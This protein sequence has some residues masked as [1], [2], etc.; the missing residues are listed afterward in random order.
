VLKTPLKLPAGLRSAGSLSPIIAE[1]IGGVRGPFRLERL[2][3]PSNGYADER[4]ERQVV[5][6]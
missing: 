2:R 3:R 6:D 4:A 5:G 1:I